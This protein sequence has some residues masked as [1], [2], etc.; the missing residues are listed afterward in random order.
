[1]AGQTP[2]LD[3]LPQLVAWL[4]QSLRAQPE[5]I[6]ATNR[7]T[8][9]QVAALLSSPA[10]GTYTALTVE[11][12]LLL[13][14]ATTNKSQA[15]ELAAML[16][17]FR[18]REQR[19]TRLLA[20]VSG[21]RQSP[22]DTTAPERDALE[23][24]ETLLKTEM[25][26]AVDSL[27]DEVEKHFA[28]GDA[29]KNRAGLAWWVSWD[30]ARR[31]DQIVTR[32]GEAQRQC[33]LNEVALGY[34]RGLLQAVKSEPADDAVL[35]E[36]EMR[37]TAG[38]CQA[39][40]TTLN[41]WL[42]QQLEGRRTN[43]L[44]LLAGARAEHAGALTGRAESLDRLVYVLGSVSSTRL[45]DLLAGIEKRFSASRKDRASFD[46]L[47]GWWQELERQQRIAEMTVLIAGVATT[48][49][50]G[51]S[52]QESLT[53]IIGAL[54]KYAPAQADEL[55]NELDRR[56][57]VYDSGSIESLCNWWKEYRNRERRLACI[58]RLVEAAKR[59][60]TEARGET[61][62]QLTNSVR[63]LSAREVEPILREIEVKISSSD[64]L[65]L[66]QLLSWFEKRFLAPP[67]WSVVVA[68]T[69]GATDSKQANDLATAFV[70][71]FQ[72]K[73]FGAKVKFHEQPLEI[74]DEAEIA[75]FCRELDA[76]AVLLIRLL[77]PE[78]RRDP[79]SVLGP[80]T[81]ADVSVQVAGI[82]VGSPIQTSVFRGNYIDP[83][84]NPMEHVIRKAY[85]DA[86]QKASNDASLA[87]ALGLKAGAAKR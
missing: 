16:Q 22:A 54:G 72:T 77:P 59:S 20:V 52:S 76:K 34:Y 26:P 57:D 17:R 38:S 44:A 43:L 51:N 81:V 27:C 56:L 78:T 31:R 39:L 14:A 65:T 25:P 74:V 35:G 23:R 60:P 21:L 48:R 11:L 67:S 3:R 41:W 13:P 45:Q 70:K 68:V 40:E 9:Q 30:R 83:R 32:L 24:L 19:R 37:L 33:G 47:L 7:A 71:Q 82:K 66:R 63:V 85:E 49:P 5:V 84:N 1:A 2:A 55:L 58:T 42:E 18:E 15:K 46:A 4:Q 10:G 75:S 50:A 12:E 28:A 79:N 87:E 53:Q 73:F 64:S 62:R 86:V 36:V 61:F 6:N 29:A 80:V 8:G 69:E